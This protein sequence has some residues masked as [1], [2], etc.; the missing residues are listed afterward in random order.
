MK[1][2]LF[3]TLSVTFCFGLAAQNSESV[4]IPDKVAQSTI[5]NDVPI[6][7]SSMLSLLQGL[8]LADL[9]APPVQEKTYPLSKGLFKK[10]YIEQAIEICPSISKSKVN[11]SQLLSKQNIDEINDT[12]YGLNF[13]Y[14]LI[15]IP[16]HE[17]EGKL[18]LN[19][20]GFAYNIGFITS[21]AS[22]DRYGTLCDLMAKIGLETCHNRKIGIGFDFLAGYGKTAG[23][24]F[25]YKNIITDSEPS[26]VCPY[27][28]WGTKY[29]GQFWLKTGSLGSNSWTNNTDVL[30]FARL[31]KAPDPEKIAT[32]S[33]Y[34]FNLWREE[35]WSFG[36][37]LRYRM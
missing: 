30:L 36:I 29:G 32:A 24:F 4:G 15:F 5:A 31:I 34:S 3:V 1:K 20:F 6:D 8:N 21:F 27:T 26:A 13:G 16:G 2:L 33:L 22:T 23:D 17:Q 11:Q 25:T 10:H 18:H 14:S 19:K 35:N 28:L 12:G 9:N 7:P 37:I